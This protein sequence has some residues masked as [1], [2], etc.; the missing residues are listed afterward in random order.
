MGGVMR[1]LFVSVML[2]AALLVLTPNGSP[3]QERSS[4]LWQNI[5]F[6]GTVTYADAIG[7]DCIFQTG[8][9]VTGQISVD[10]TGYPVYS[11]ANQGWRVFFDVSPQILL[12]QNA[13]GT[14]RT[15]TIYPQWNEGNGE[16]IID[17][18]D[19]IG[20]G[21]QTLMNWGYDYLE[22]VTPSSGEAVNG[23]TF[24]PKAAGVPDFVFVE[25]ARWGD[26]PSN[27]SAGY[28]FFAINITL[29]TWDCL[30]GY[31]CEKD[32]TQWP[33][34]PPDKTAIEAFIVR[35]YQQFWNRPPDQGNI[36]YWREGF[37]KGSETALDLIN[38]LVGTD[39]FTSRT[40]SNQ[41]FIEILHEAFFNT[42]V[43]SEDLQ[44]W[45][46]D[47]ADGTHTRSSLLEELLYSDKF[48]GVCARFGIYVSPGNV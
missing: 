30:G 37:L 24:S 43:G 47:L 8:D 31:L 6:T 16:L 48:Q 25:W 17:Y 15:I 14:A 1:K 32:P 4:T 27:I 19:D 40:L 10:G 39:D 34:P 11:F 44:G 28:Q 35:C 20:I 23:A 12:K 21:H 7:T 18:L 42:K 38:F 26:D 41:E 22:W 5:I 46:A 3:A 33:V 2:A 29:S 36:N 45:L 13:T 9:A